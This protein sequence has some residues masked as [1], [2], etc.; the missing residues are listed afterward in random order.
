MTKS[1]I[2]GVKRGGPNKGPKDFKRKTA[3]V[4]RKVKRANV[5][6]IKIAA[7]HI[8][9]PLQASMGLVSKH[10]ERSTLTKLYKQL[11]H[12]SAPTR[13]QALN[14]IAKIV[15]TSE[16]TESYI[17]ILVP[18]SLELLFDNDADTRKAL[19]ILMSDIIRR[20][21]TGAFASTFSVVVTYICSGLTSLTAAIQRDSLSLLHKFTEVHAALVVPHARKL[22]VNVAALMA[23]AASRAPAVALPTSTNQNAVSG[24]KNISSNGDSKKKHV[25][26]IST[27]DKKVAHLQMVM[28]VLR[29][30]CAV[31]S[32]KGEVE[33]GYVECKQQMRSRGG[34]YK[35]FS[36]SAD[37][38]SHLILCPRAESGH[39]ADVSGD[40]WNPLQEL[41]ASFC[42]QMRILW[43]DL[44]ERPKLSPQ[45]VS[46]LLEVAQVALVLCRNCSDVSQ[47][48]KFKRL[49]LAC[50]KGFPYSRR[51]AS[52]ATST[53][54]DIQA[55][56]MLQ[57]VD[58]TL[59]E[60][61]FA[62]N[63]QMDGVSTMMVSVS[64]Y[65]LDSLGSQIS[66]LESFRANQKDEGSKKERNEEKEDD[67]EPTVREFDAPENYKIF[68][69]MK[70]KGKERFAGDRMYQQELLRC[71]WRCVD[72]AL[73]QFTTAAASMDTIS[74]SDHSSSLQKLVTVLQSFISVAKSEKGHVCDN[75]G[76]YKL[77]RPAIISICNACCN[78]NLWSDFNFSKSATY[79]SLCRCLVELPPLLTFPVGRENVDRDLQEVYLKSLHTLV[80]RT[81]AD[82]SHMLSLSACMHSLFVAPPGSNTLS[83]YSQCD[84]ALRIFLLTIWHA[85]PFSKDLL[86][87]IVVD[88]T[89][90]VI[91]QG[92]LPSATLCKVEE[93]LNDALH[94]QRHFLRMMYSRRLE[95]TV[96]DVLD[97]LFVMLAD[98][99]SR[100]RI[101]Q[102]SAADLLSVCLRT[103]RD[104]WL[105][106]DIA[107]MFH[108]LSS[109]HA[110][111]KIFGFITDEME[112][113]CTQQSMKNKPHNYKSSAKNDAVL[114]V[115][116]YLSHSGA[117][118]TLVG[119]LVPVFHRFSMVMKEVSPAREVLKAEER[120]QVLN[121]SKIVVRLV[122]TGSAGLPTEYLKVFCETSGHGIGFDA[123]SVDLTLLQPFVSALCI[124]APMSVG[125][126]DDEAVRFPLLAL[127]IRELDTQFDQ[128]GDDDRLIILKSAKR[129]LNHNKLVEAVHALRGTIETSLKKFLLSLHLL[130]GNQRDSSIDISQLLSSIP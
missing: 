43:L 3:K 110:P 9:I 50:F 45:I 91:K 76:S 61:T 22:V 14:A 30:I 23:D 10:D 64:D 80:N 116:H 33:K 65:L 62:L 53:I 25:S 128:A 114:S 68:P 40:C 119:L 1:G 41:E 99:T 49:L 87:R 28:Q 60:I 92:Y 102:L 93:H 29:S 101:K 5:T 96:D 126:A 117:L 130:H 17:S 108:T 123:H 38:S 88:V 39:S 83:F 84:S 67:S 48:Q 18:K 54:D 90:C 75:S 127:F 103:A 97:A 46:V 69:L 111:T 71:L 125:T 19:L 86:P 79:E 7:K 100:V 78:S 112:S 36:A 34:T 47:F 107:Q 51:F 72:L 24:G 2:D 37:F 21:Q 59:S 4:G 118:R 66:R 13:L 121:I 44:S 8:H 95:M 124:D 12:Y 56:L 74:R 113:L 15:A 73:S 31:H 20:H 35:Q 70:Q 106:M 81:T 57:V 16:H 55:S 27:T 85:T 109:S 32:A 115:S 98:T 105:G 58:L 42:D 120:E 63:Q 11:Q 26:T 104:D 122:V 94:E 89:Q 82:N 6:E 52:T 129:I 77:V